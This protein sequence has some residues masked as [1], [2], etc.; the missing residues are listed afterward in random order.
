MAVKLGSARGDERGKITG[1][2][3]G[4]QTGKEVSTQSWYKHSK[5]WRVFR[6]KDPAKAE[7]VAACME[8]ACGCSHIGY[9]QNQR[10]TLYSALKELAWQLT[11]LKKDVETD[12]SALVRVCLAYAGVFVSDFNT[13]SEASRLLA[14]GEIVE[15][16]GSKYTS[17]SDYLRRG[18]ILVTRTK[19]HTVVVL[20][21]GSKAEKNVPAPSTTPSASKPRTLG[22]RILKEGMEGDDVKELQRQLIQLGYSC[23]SYGIDGDFG[24]ATELAVRKFQKDHPPLDVD[25]EAGPLTIAALEKAL[26]ADAQTGRIVEI[27]G[28]QCYVRTAPNTSTGKKLGVAKEGSKLPYGGEQSAD[29]WLLV[30]FD[31]GNGWVSGKYGKLVS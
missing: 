9:D 13:S 28:G 25:G 15:L 1:G 31:N 10:N 21:D 19:G 24:D 29:G 16:T 5:G 17:K 23:G 30:E 26:G 7:K 18:D 14:S 22:S 27:M 3:A 6:L 8:W 4:D 2:K 20:S 12:C 11:K